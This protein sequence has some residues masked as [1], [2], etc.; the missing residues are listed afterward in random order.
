MID[1]LLFC[2]FLSAKAAFPY[3]NDL[4]Y[5]WTCKNVEESP[6]I[7]YTTVHSLPIVSNESPSNGSGGCFGTGIGRLQPTSRVIQFQSSNLTVGKYIRFQVFV[8]KDTRH[9]DTYT[10]CKVVNP[11]PKF[12]VR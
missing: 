8:T 11:P 10:D 6:A 7:T 2:L 9:A 12:T 5:T 3:A 4:S 1:W